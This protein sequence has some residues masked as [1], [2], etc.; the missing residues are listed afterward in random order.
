MIKPIISGI[1]K[2]G[3]F[4]AERPDLC[5]S[6]FYPYEGKKVKITVTEFK[7]T[8]SNYQNKY[9]HGVCYK[10]I[11]D[12]TGHSSDE[13]HDE[14][15]GMFLRKRSNYFKSVLGS[16]RKLSTVEFEEYTEN[17][18]RWASMGLNLYIPLPNETDLEQL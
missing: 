4:V 1:V 5:K 6:M 13:V 9:L 14:M 7:K 17:I 8:R 12:Y 15:R 3:K 16:T 11:A 18:R 10:M 2:G